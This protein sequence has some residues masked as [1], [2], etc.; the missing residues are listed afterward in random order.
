MN[1]SIAQ[2]INAES[3]ND[4]AIAK[5]EYV[6]VNNSKVNNIAATNITD[7]GNNHLSAKFAGMFPSAQNQQWAKDAKGYW[8]SF[9]NEGRKTRAGFNNNGKLNYT[10][11]DCKSDQLST[12]FRKFIL[13][14][15][16]DYQLF[17][18]IIINAFGEQ[19]QQAILENTSGFVTLRSSK[20]GIEE[21]QKIRKAH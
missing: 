1:N 19:A 13:K 17:N 7:P 2:D 14:N 8:V 15:Y 16:P 10:I 21:I 5:N 6:A 18:A 3:I 20:D 9:S 4:V 12:K 11:E